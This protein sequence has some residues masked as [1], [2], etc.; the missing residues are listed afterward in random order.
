[1]HVLKCIFNTKSNKIIIPEFGGIF[2]E[3]LLKFLILVI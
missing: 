1:M 2:L 3:K